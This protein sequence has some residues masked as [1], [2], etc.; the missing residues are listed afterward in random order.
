MNKKIHFSFSVPIVQIFHSRRILSLLMQ[1]SYLQFLFSVERSVYHHEGRRQEAV[2]MKK[3]SSPYMKKE[4]SLHP[5]PY[6]P[7]PFSSQE[8]GGRS[9]KSEVILPHLPHLPH[10]PTWNST[11]PIAVTYKNTSNVL[12]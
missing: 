8:A 4:Y 5:T 6:T 9:R 7:H 10:S 1:A 3:F 12:E 2:P 11:D